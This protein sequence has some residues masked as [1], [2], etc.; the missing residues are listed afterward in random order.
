MMC[1]PLIEMVIE[2][3]LV[4]S[5]TDHQRKLFSVHG[6]HDGPSIIFIAGLHGNEPSGVHAMQHLFRAIEPLRSSMKGSVHGLTGNIG[7]LRSSDRYL[8]TDLNRIWSVERVEE[9]RQ[10]KFVPQVRDESEQV[11]LL[12]A[13][14]EILTADTGPFYFMDLHTTSSATNPFVVVNDSL[15]NRRFTRQYP[16]PIILGIEEYLDG[17]LLSYISELGYVAFGFEAGQHDDPDATARDLAFAR[18]SLH[19]CGVL[20][21]EVFPVIEDAQFLEDASN[22][23]ANFFEIFYRYR[24]SEGEHF[25]MYPGYV[26]FQRISLGQQ[27]ATSEGKPIYADRNAR[28]FMPLYQSQ[29]SEGFFAIRSIPSIFLKLS[30]LLRNSNADRLLTWLPGVHWASA[31]R[32]ALIVDR[33]VARFFAKQVFHLL[34]Y[35]SR[36]RDRDHYIMKNR[37]VASRDEAYADAPWM[38]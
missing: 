9:I 2:D 11:E 4:E 31:S 20:D 16:L 34:G 22:G 29:G 6:D 14:D 5:T 3:S 38:R 7:A 25:E 27:F 10:G 30:A 23:V 24:I 33:K 1:K 19:L 13:I 32:E 12:Q 37:E 21:E 8:D 18:L 15:L 36:R 26:N 28:V 17:P 35:R